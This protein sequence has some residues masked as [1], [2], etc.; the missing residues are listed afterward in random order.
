MKNRPRL[1]VAVVAAWIVLA[2]LIYLFGYWKSFLRLLQ[3]LLSTS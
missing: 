1:W 2:H 3:P